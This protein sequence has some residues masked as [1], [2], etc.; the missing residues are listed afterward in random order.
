M[1]TSIRARVPIAIL[2]FALGGLG[3]V[4]K[5]TVIIEYDQPFNVISFNPSTFPNATSYAEVHGETGLWVVY[6]I[7]RVSNMGK[8]AMLFALDR[9]RFTTAERK[10][11][12]LTLQPQ[13]VAK[14]LQDNV[15]TLPPTLPVKPHENP[16]INAR[17]VLYVPVGPGDINAL[18]KQKGLTHLKYEAPN[19]SIL[20]VRKTPVVQPKN[21]EPATWKDLKP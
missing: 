8:D 10:S 4:K 18:A 17:I 21:L 13:S 16:Q 9:D 11:N 5:D 7:I 6:D 12:N 14:E 2:I 1:R 19:Q 20:I 15:V 3:C